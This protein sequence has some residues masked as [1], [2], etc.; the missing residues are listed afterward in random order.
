MVLPL[1]L[2]KVF[3]PTA[4]GFI[5]GVAITPVFTHY[6]YKYKI[7]KR[8]SR[9]EDERL[10]T[11]EISE[12]FKKIHNTEAE[13]STPRAGGII[14]W[15]SV[16][17][18]LLVIFIISKVFPTPITEKL[19]FL[20][21]GQTLLPFFALIIGSLIGLADDLM[22]TF[23]KVGKFVNGFPRRWMVGI[24]TII[25]LVGGWWFF[26][27]LGISTIA[28][29]FNGSLELGMLFIPVFIVVVLATFSSG[30]IDGIDGLAGGVFAIIF[31][32]YAFLAY[33]Q[34]QIDLAAFCGVIT[35]GIL[36]FLWFNIPPARFYM[37]ETGMLGLTITLALVA[38]LT[39]TVLLLPII[40]LPLTVTALSSALQITSKKL[41]GPEGKI[42]K[43][44]PLHHHFES[45]GWS[46]EKITMRYWIISIVFAVIGIIIALIA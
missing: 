20:S 2:I 11:E 23:V 17:I 1:N 5:I 42:F 24:V 25:G 26:T 7:W 21:R 33:F 8:T 18:T 29:P 30:V 6:F 27:K 22:A 10:D 34:N 28:I 46:R 37:G 32:A 31:A 35:G 41:F 19:D 44:A 13:L 38:F 12:H 16:L 9:L 40:A 39:D 36:A 14:I 45:I 15:M 4:I 43:V 3:L